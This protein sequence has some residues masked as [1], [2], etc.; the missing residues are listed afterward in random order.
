MSDADFNKKE[1]SCIAH[2]VR[3]LTRAGADGNYLVHFGETTVGRPLL[4]KLHSRG[5]LYQSGWYLSGRACYVLND[6]GCREARKLV[7]HTQ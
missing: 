4:K 7:R 3:N 1:L 5:W 2:L 6:T